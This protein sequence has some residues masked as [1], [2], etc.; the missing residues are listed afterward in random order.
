MSL[1]FTITSFLYSWLV[2][3]GYISLVGCRAHVYMIIRKVAIEVAA[4]DRAP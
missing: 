3:G 1:P 2:Q 4:I